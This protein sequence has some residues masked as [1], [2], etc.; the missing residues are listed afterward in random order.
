MGVGN[1]DGHAGLGN[2]RDVENVE[3]HGESQDERLADEYQEQWLTC[4]MGR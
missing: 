4:W 3:A 2:N 1:G